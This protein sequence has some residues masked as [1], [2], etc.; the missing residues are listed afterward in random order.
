MFI[1]VLKMFAESE[2]WFQILG[3]FDKVFHFRFFYSICTEPI[4]NF[5]FSNSTCFMH[6]NFGSKCL[7]FR[8]DFRIKFFYPFIFFNNNI[9]SL[10]CIMPRKSFCV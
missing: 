3:A 7:N 6:C 2:E 8:I 9:Q 1:V 4:I 5:Y 10:H